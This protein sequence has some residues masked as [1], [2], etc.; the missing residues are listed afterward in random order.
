MQPT[1]AAKN[2]FARSLLELDKEFSTAGE[3]KTDE[4]AVNKVGQPSQVGHDLPV[5]GNPPSSQNQRHT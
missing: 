1:N 2:I 4:A 5:A 3:A